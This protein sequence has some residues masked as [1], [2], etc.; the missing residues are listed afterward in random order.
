MP[1][2][3]TFTTLQKYSGFVYDTR[4]ILDVRVMKMA[5]MN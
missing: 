3:V 1:P 4:Y 5:V 2:N